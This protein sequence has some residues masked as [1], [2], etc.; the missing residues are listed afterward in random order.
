M[1]YG[2]GRLR[3]NPPRII[4][5]FLTI[6]FFFCLRY[7]TRAGLVSHPST[8]TLVKVSNCESKLVLKSDEKTPCIEGPIYPSS[9]EANTH[10]KSSG[11]KG[12]SQQEAGSKNDNSAANAI[13]PCAA[14]F[15]FIMFLIV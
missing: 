9:T 12:A 7:G 3:T 1:G 4:L 15:F 2:R 5:V 13:R 11:A 6:I 8:C 10:D 14:I